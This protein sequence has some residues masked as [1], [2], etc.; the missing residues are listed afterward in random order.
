M[1]LETGDLPGRTG[2]GHRHGHIESLLHRVYPEPGDC[3]F[4]PAGTVHALGAGILVA[5]VQQASD[6]TFRLHD[7][8]R[9]GPDG[10]S[11]PLHIQAALDVI[12][13]AAGPRHPQ[14]VHGPVHSGRER[15]VTCDKFC[16]DRLRGPGAAS[17]AAD[18]HFHLLTAPHGGVRLRGESF[19]EQLTI[20]DSVLLPAAHGDLAI[21][22]QADGLLLDVYLPAT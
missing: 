18:G 11:R 3:I 6:T 15:L 5:E 1:R 9:T 12:D 19:T 10:Q 16:L 8:N 17:L 7:W 20:G 22:L 4:I 14:S 2:G 21:E 13:F